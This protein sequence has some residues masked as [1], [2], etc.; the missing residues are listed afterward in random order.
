MDWRATAPGK[1]QRPEY[2][3]CAP[4]G[5]SQPAFAQQAA[6]QAAHMPPQEAELA[7]LASRLLRVV[8]GSDSLLLHAQLRLALLG[9]AGSADS[10]AA[11]RSKSLLELALA[12]LVQQGLIMRQGYGPL[13]TL[14]V[15]DAALSQAEAL[16]YS[17]FPDE[18]QLGLLHSSSSGSGFTAQRPTSCLARLRRLSSPRQFGGRMS[19]I[20]KASGR[21]SKRGMADAELSTCLAKKMRVQEDSGDGTVGNAMAA[22]SGQPGVV[23]PG[24]VAMSP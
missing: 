8:L 9:K 3:W 19:G 12:R 15:P 20:E 2:G 5:A 14:S 22:C 11:S 6:L 23:G 4:H 24:C 13:A 10:A 7:E 18:A 17:E 1:Q 16:A 21:R